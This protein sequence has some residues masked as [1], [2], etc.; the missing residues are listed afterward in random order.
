MLKEAGNGG[1]FIETISGLGHHTTGFV[2]V[3]ETDLITVNMNDPH[4]TEWE[5]FEEMQD[6]IDWWQGGLWASGGAIVPEKRFIYP[7]AF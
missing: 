4:I 7:I 1:H 6:S 2:F 3:D 5:I